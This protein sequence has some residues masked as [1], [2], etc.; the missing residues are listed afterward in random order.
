METRA[1]ES[2]IVSAQ[3]DEENVDIFAIS[4]ATTATF[5]DLYF[6]KTFFFFIQRGT[7]WVTTPSQRKMIGCQGDLMIFS[8]GSMVTMENRPLLNEDYRAVGVSFS[9]SLIETVY[10]DL[11]PPKATPAVQIVSA[12]EHHP[13]EILDLLQGTLENDAL[14]TSIRRHRLLEPLIWLRDL[15]V[16]LPMGMEKNPI[17]RVRKL[18]ETD[19]SQTWHSNEVAQ[20][21]GM[22]EATMR[23][24][25]A[26]TGQGFSKIL[27]HTR[28]E[29]GLSLLQTTDERIS[30]ISLECGFKT[31]SHFSGA[32]RKR[33]GIKPNEIRQEKK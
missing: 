28:L 27:L 26:K 13:S 9:Q 29:R 2:N 17:S 12:A 21:F 11:P 10:A 31:P 8:P 23:R 32:F 4:Q 5:T 15:G 1:I 7:K 20:H 24:W 18:L 30:Q 14:P 3:Q 25:L 33:F 6:R 19:L 16:H 22:S